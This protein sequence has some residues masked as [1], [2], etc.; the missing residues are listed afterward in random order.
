MPKMVLADCSG[1]GDAVIGQ[2]PRGFQSTLTTTAKKALVRRVLPD[3]RS[4]PLLGGVGM[5]FMLH[6]LLFFRHFPLALSTFVAAISRRYRRHVARH[7]RFPHLACLLHR[8][9][10]LAMTF[11]QR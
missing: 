10:V 5:M 7:N 1:L 4:I 2:D 3:I 8:T 9:P 6:Q 11:H